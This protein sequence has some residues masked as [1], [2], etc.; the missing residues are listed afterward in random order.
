SEIAA[1]VPCVVDCSACNTA[2]LSLGFGNV[3]RMIKIEGQ[4]GFGG[5]K[6]ILIACEGAASRSGAAAGQCADQGALT[7]TGEPTDHRAQARAAAGHDTGALAFP[8]LDSRDCA[9]RDG[10]ASPAR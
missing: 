7:A 4:Q 6:D 1:Q 2:K 8:F 9:G 5:Q 3:D 10:V